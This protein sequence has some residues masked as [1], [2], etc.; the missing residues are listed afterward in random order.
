MKDSLFGSRFLSSKQ[1]T[2]YTQ[3]LLCTLIPLVTDTSIAEALWTRT[4]TIQQNHLSENMTFFQ[5]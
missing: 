3:H 5:Q 1:L 4:I 2:P